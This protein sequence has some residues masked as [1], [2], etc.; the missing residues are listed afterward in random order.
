MFVFKTECFMTYTIAFNLITGTKKSSLPLISSI[1]TFVTSLKL[2]TNIL[3]MSKVKIHY[4]QK[5]FIF[6]WLHLYMTNFILYKLEIFSQ[7]I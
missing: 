4:H 5:R 1:T 7:C 2:Y 3:L 6:N